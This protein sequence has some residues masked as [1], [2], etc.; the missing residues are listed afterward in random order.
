VAARG[1]FIHEMM[2]IA[3]FENVFADRERYP[4]ITL[5]TLAAAQPDCIL[6]SS[7][8]YP[9]AEKHIAVFRE[10]C[11]GAQVRIVDGEL[12]SWYGSRL[13]HAPDYFR[14]LS[15]SFQLD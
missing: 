12:F 6:L 14:A 1:T 15:E 10:T 9:F 11:P 2:H 7:E 13:R 3:G 5:D 4:E 8:P